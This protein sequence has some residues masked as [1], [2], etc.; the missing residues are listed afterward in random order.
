MAA[1]LPARRSCTWT[2]TPGRPRPTSRARSAVASEQP[3]ASDHDLDDA[4]NS[5]L[6]LEERGVK[7]TDVL[8]ASL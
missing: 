6:L 8:A 7:L 1:T 2:W 4:R 5:G 3:L